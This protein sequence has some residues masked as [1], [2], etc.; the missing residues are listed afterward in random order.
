MPERKARPKP[1]NA[2]EILRTWKFWENKKTTSEIILASTVTRKTGFRPIVSV[3]PPN[4][5]SIAIVVTE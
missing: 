3:K 2:N 4:G 5:S 1:I